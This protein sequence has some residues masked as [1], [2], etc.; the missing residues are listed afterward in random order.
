M[1]IFGL[2]ALYFNEN[3]YISLSVPQ[4]ISNTFSVKRNIYSSF[5]EF[6]NIYLSGGYA[7]KL[8]DGIRLRPNLLLV[9]TP[10]K[11]IKFDAAAVLYLPADLQLGFNLRSTGSVCLSA[12]YTIVHNLKIGFA[13]EYAII[14]D[15]RNYQMG[16]F[17]LA[18]G[19]Y[20]NQKKGKDMRPRYF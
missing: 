17:E 16:T 9:G 4:I 2:G 8:I 11:S 15:I 12:Q 3:Y 6:N 10:G 14:R 18:V 5:Q 20:F 7:F 1:S 13:V 19:Y